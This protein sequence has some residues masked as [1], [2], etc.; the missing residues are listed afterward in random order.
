MH[1]LL[2]ILPRYPMDEWLHFA[3]Q[4]APLNTDIEISLQKVRNVI[5]KFLRF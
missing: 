5:E 1:K 3:Q 4:Y 2:E